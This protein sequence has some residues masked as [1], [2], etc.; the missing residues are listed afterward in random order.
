LTSGQH[1]G[2]TSRL[3]SRS[4]GSTSAGGLTESRR[5]VLSYAEVIRKHFT[6]VAEMNPDYSDYTDYRPDGARER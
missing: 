1:P 5:E 3:A 2:S 4:P 6:R